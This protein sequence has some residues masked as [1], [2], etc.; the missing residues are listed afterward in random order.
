M[1]TKFIKSGSGLWKPLKQWINK[2]F[3]KKDDNDNFY[4]NPYAV[5]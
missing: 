4:D 1:K 5:L 3:R 2:I